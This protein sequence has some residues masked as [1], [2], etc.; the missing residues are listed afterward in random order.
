MIAADCQ[1][2]L[3]MR[4]KQAADVTKNGRHLASKAKAQL[5]HNNTP[6]SCMLW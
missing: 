1:Q 5:Q 6:R 2:A 4:M 3:D